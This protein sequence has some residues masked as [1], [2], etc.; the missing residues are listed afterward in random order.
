MAIEKEVIESIKHGV[1]LM[2]LVQAKG[3]QLKKNGKGYLGFAPSTQK[4][5]HHYP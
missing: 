5:T 2:A 1:D 3:T 4:K